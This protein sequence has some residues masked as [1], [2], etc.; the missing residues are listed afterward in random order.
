[1]SK[2]LLGLG[3]VLDTLVSGLSSVTS[4]GTLWLPLAAGLM[5]SMPSIGRWAVAFA[6]GES[7]P[8]PTLWHLRHSENSQW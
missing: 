7:E 1:M 2:S 6:Y 4:H 3:L 5:A 8:T